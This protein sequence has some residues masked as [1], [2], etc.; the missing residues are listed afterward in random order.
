[1]NQLLTAVPTQ[2]SGRAT[3]NTRALTKAYFIRSSRN[4][5]LHD[6]NVGP[7][8]GLRGGYLNRGCFSDIREACLPIVCAYLI[9]PLL[10]HPSGIYGRGAVA[11]G[12]AH[13]VRHIGDIAIAQDICKRPHGFPCAQIHA[14]G[15]RGTV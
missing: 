4:K 12:A 5:W 14:L 13:I 3:S 11:P 1:M 7:A 6:Q 15:W 10:G 2:S 9:L 8:A